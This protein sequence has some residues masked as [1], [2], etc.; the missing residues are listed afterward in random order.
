MS[1][2]FP[3]ARLATVPA[4]TPG[5]AA[6]GFVVR[7]GRRVG[8]SIAEADPT[9]GPAPLWAT[10]LLLPQWAHQPAG[11]TASSLVAI[12]Q[13]AA[14]VATP[15][16]AQ[17]SLARADGA[18]VE[19]FGNTSGDNVGLTADGTADMQTRHNPAFS[20]SFIPRSSVA[21]VRY[22]VGLFASTPMGSAT[23]AVELAGFRYDTGAGDAGWKAFT[24]DGA[25]MTQ[26]GSTLSAPVVDT[27]E[28]MLIV[29]RDAGAAIEFWRGTG[30]Y[31]NGDALALVGV[32]TANLP[33]TSTSLF[34]RVQVRL[35][36]S[37]AKGL[38]VA[39]AAGFWS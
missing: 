39:R 15:A 27:R 36:S 26:V 35:L 16:S 10:P 23:P 31:E 38:A 14:T 34:W 3:D 6:D 9:W 13:A 29:V 4:L 37:A 30:R 21:S 1:D 28:N 2:V 12:G 22:W 32:A 18:Y 5:V 20:A 8:A 17:A 25:T 19:L 11:A 7:G 33:T 24:R